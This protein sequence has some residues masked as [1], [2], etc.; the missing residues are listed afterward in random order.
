[1]LYESCLCFEWPAEALLL[2]QSRSQALLP[3][4]RGERHRAAL[5][6]ALSHT[7]LRPG[8]SPR[9]GEHTPGC[10]WTCSIWETIFRPDSTVEF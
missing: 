9:D 8:A 7:F 4:S 1:M 2:S 5:E 6:Q 3:P 10:A